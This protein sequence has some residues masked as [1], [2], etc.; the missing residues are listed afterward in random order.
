MDNNICRCRSCNGI[1]H[2]VVEGDTL[3]L[4][5]RKYNVSVGM[6]IRENRGINPYNLMIGEKICIPV[7]RY[8]EYAN[9][10]NPNRFE[11]NM[12]REMSNR[13]NRNVG[14]SLEENVDEGI[15][16]KYDMEFEE[17]REAGKISRDTD[18]GDIINIENMTVGKFADIIKNI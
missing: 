1:V 9:D 10:N 14:N 16:E 3:Y 5:G 17:I 18:L 4:L 6:I 15:E 11:N 8:N 2:E 12:N 7:S 13:A